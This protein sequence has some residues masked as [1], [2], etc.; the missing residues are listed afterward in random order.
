MLFTNP[1]KKSKYHNSMY[2][3]PHHNIPKQ[4]LILTLTNIH[5]K[6]GQSKTF[7]FEYLTFDLGNRLG[8]F[9]FFW[10][11]HPS[12]MSKREELIFTQKLDDVCL[13]K[14]IVF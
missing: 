10:W 6:S 1:T 13:L 12:S 2:L 4:H 9:G 5:L 8:I 3:L 7:F 11:K 14:L